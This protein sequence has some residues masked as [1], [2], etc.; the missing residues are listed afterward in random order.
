[1]HLAPPCTL[2]P[3]PITGVC[4]KFTESTVTVSEADG[5]AAIHL[6]ASKGASDP[7]TVNVIPS[8]G[9]ALGRCNLQMTATTVKYTLLVNRFVEWCSNGNLSEIMLVYMSH[10]RCISFVQLRKTSM[11]QL[12]L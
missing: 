7:Y 4:V 1:M 3:P 8:P 2:A 6:R 10:M 9:S 5:K 12:S 11:V